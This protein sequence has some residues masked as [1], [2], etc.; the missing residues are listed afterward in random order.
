MVQHH[1]GA[2][3][4]VLCNLSHSINQLVVVVSVVVIMLTA[5]RQVP[6]PVLCLPARI[7]MGT[8]CH[9]CTI[10]NIDSYY[11]IKISLCFLTWLFQMLPGPTDT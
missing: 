5:A 1:H 8:V 7:S 4:H 11:L 2:E 3:I 6:H 9:C 10:C